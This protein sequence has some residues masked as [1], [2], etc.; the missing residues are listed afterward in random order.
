MDGQFLYLAD[1]LVPLLYRVRP[2][3]GI[4]DRAYLKID[5]GFAQQLRID[6]AIEV[7]TVTFQY[8]VQVYLGHLPY[9]FFERHLLQ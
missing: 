5:Y 7:K 4:Q 1:D 2:V 3:K 8:N 9:F 6:R